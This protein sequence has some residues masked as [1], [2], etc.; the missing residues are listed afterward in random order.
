MTTTTTTTLLL[1]MMVVVFL[2]RH[3]SNPVSHQTTKDV[4]ESMP[5]DCCPTTS[6]A[7]ATFCV[8]PPMTMLMT[9]MPPL[10]N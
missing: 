8:P 1:V 7:C 6:C 9:M 10:P 2:S 3:W 5:T 4:D